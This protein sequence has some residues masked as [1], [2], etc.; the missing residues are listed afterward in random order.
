MNTPIARPLDDYSPLWPLWRAQNP[1]V[2]I[3]CG[4]DA[5]DGGDDGADDGA[6]DDKSGGEGDDKGDKGGKPDGLMGDPGDK[7]PGKPDNRHPADKDPKDEP[8]DKK[9]DD[10]K[11]DADKGKRPDHIPEK[12]WDAE[13]GTVKTDEMAKAYATL[14]TAHGKLK[15]NPAMKGDVPEKAEDY[16]GDKGL[17][18]PDDIKIDRVKDIPADDPALLAAAKAAKEAGIPRD[19]LL[20]FAP[21]FLGHLN[22]FLPEPMD[23]DAEMESLGK[24]GEALVTG[25][26]TWLDGLHDSGELSAAELKQAYQFGASADGVRVLNKLRNMTGQQPIPMNLPSGDGLPSKEELYAAKRSDKYRTDPAYREKIE[27]QF[28]QVF[29][30]EPAGTSQPGLGMPPQGAPRNT[31]KKG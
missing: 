31:N 24:G 28:E 4:A 19:V 16:F 26:K 8:G 10:K 29:G 3:G 11:N 18:I 15:G 27:K 23:V 13:K 25:L 5:A 9:P 22:E 17:T 20:A 6:G 30:T 21:K 1:G 12:F 7:K 2:V 14:E